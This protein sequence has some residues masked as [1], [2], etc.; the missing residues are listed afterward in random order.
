MLFKVIYFMQNEAFCVEFI[1]HLACDLRVG[2]PEMSYKNLFE[3]KVTGCMTFC[4]Q[5][6]G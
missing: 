3:K 6:T 2:Q 4:G 5:L 1:S